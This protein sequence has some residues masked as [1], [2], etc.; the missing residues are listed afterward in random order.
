MGY[1][2]YFWGM[3]WIWWCVWLILLV[4][5]FAIPFS[6][7]GQRYAKD[8][9]IDILKRRFAYGEITVEE[10]REKKKILEEDSAKDTAKH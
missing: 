7:P 9:P 4:W 6:I 10:Y 8:T 3:H 1:Y 2:N 5:I